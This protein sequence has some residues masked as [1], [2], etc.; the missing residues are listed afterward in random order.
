MMPRLKHLDLSDNALTVLPTSFTKLRNLEYLNL[1][2]NS[3]TDLPSGFEWFTKLQTLDVRGNA[4]PNQTLEILR[5]SLP[6]C[7]IIK[8]PP[9]RK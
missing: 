1:R 5:I 8:D 4:I 7:K 6:D 2:N 3:L 9:P